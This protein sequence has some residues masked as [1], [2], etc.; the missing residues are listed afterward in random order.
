MPSFFKSIMDDHYELVPK[1]LL[2]ELKEENK[3]LKEELSKKQETPSEP[4]K[5]DK[6]ML[7]ELRFMLS[8]HS[9]KQHEALLDELS[10][11]KEINSQNLQSLI[12]KTSELDSR[13]EKMVESLK[14]LIGD[15]SHLIEDVSDSREEEYKDIINKTVE[16]MKKLQPSHEEKPQEEIEQVVL[17]KKLDDIERFLTNL[18]ILLSYVKPNDLVLEKSEP[19]FSQGPTT[20]QNK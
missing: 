14:S 18:R 11:I 12:S 1:G 15:F 8:E 20:P 6:S 9:K 13:L 3:K 7:S 4:Q 2:K 10:S 5:V 17:M 19:S 16:E